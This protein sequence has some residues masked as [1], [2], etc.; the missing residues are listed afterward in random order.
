MNSDWHRFQQEISGRNPACRVTVYGQPMKL[1]EAHR[2]F[3]NPDVSYHTFRARVR[4][5]WD[6]PA[7]LHAPLSSP[8][9][10]RIR[11]LDPSQKVTYNGQQIT[12]RTAFDRH[13]AQGLTWKAFVKRYHIRC[14]DLHRA[15]TQSPAKRK[16]RP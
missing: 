10:A 5:G 12:V 9:S 13:A 11:P 8:K 15:L 1:A 3:G 14:W 16:A 6:V 7:A 4:E 2:R